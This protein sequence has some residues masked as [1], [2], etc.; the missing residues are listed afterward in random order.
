MRRSELMNFLVKLFQDGGSLMWVNLAVLVLV[1]AVIAERLWSFNMRL[2]V[3]EKKFFGEVEQLVRS[4]NFDRAIST[5]NNYVGA[6]VPR[7]V[8]A[9]LANANRSRLLIA[10]AIEEAVSE[11]MPEVTKR[12]GILWGLANLATLIGLVGTVFG[13]ID[14]FGAISQAAPDKKSE[15]LTSG[16]AHAMSNTAFGLAIATFCVGAHMYLSGVARGLMMAVEHAAL[17]TENILARR[18]AGDSEPPKA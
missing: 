2:K 11:A 3:D 18:A 17:R 14:S 10:G 9:G 13:L 6:V 4:G 7:V 8:K 5:C 1:L 15:M 16:I 12:A